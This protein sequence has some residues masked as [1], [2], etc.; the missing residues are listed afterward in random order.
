MQRIVSK[1]GQPIRIESTH[2]ALRRF[3]MK[4]SRLNNSRPDSTIQFVSGVR[5]LVRGREPEILEE[6][7]PLVESRSVRL[8]L[9]AVERIDAAG[10]AALV[11]L[12]CAAGKAGHDFAVVNPSRH[13]ARILAIV[14]LDRILVTKASE[15]TLAAP[16]MKFGMVVAA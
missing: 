15:E 16:R 3:Q 13:V 12:Y 8:D 9:S 7:Q 4:N 11:S 2:N 5:Q 14:G 6:L 1:A 10:L